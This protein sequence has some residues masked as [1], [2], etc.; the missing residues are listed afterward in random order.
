M[1]GLYWRRPGSNLASSKGLDET[2][3]TPPSC[4]VRWRIEKRS[5]HQGS[6]EPTRR[7]RNCCFSKWSLENPKAD[8]DRLVQAGILRELAKVTPKTFYAPEVFASPTTILS[9]DKVANDYGA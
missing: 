8:I 6:R 1:Y 7:Q 4:Y 9:I 3:P 5:N 2:C